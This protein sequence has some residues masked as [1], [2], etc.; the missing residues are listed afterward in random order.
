MLLL[1]LRRLGLGKV[2]VVESFYR[3]VLLNVNLVQVYV[4]Y[5]ISN[6]IDSIDLT[7]ISVLGAWQATRLIAIASDI[8][9]RHSC[10]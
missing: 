8:T 1:E 5:S 7:R 3:T 2:K 10:R 4:L 9:V 6:I